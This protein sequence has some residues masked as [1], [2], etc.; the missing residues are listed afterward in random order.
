MDRP[1][2]LMCW[3]MTSVSLAAT[4]SKELKASMSCLKARSELVSEVCWER[5]VNTNSEMGS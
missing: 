3:A 1:A 2:L 5:M 4:S